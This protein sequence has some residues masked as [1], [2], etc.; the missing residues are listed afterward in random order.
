MF[1]EE[2]KDN[3]VV[4]NINPSSR[5]S[6][7]NPLKSPSATVIFRDFKIA[8]NARRGLNMKKLKGKTIRVVWHDRDNSSRY[9]SMNNLFIKN[10]PAEV[11]PREFY[12]FFL[13][14]GDIA[15]AKLPEDDDG[16]HLGYGYINYA[17]PQSAALAIKEADGSETWGSKIEVKNFQKKNE[18]FD[19][20][21][22]KNTNIYLKNFPTE[23]KE[24]DLESL[25]KKFGEVVH[26]K[27]YHDSNERNYAIVSYKDEDAALN[28]KSNLNGS[29][30]ENQ[31]I[32]VDTLMNKQD[33]KKLL[34]TQIKDYNYRINEQTKYC[35]LHIRNVPYNAKEEDLL[36]VFKP[37]GDIKS[38]KIDKYML[39]T[40]KNNEFIE[41]PTS[42]GFGYVCFENPESAAAAKEGMDGKFLPKFETWKRPLLVDF[43]MPKHER[44]QQMSKFQ[45]MGGLKGNMYNPQMMP[46]MNPMMM[47][48]MMNPQMMGYGQKGM[49][50]PQQQQGQMMNP[51][52]M[53]QQ[54]IQNVNQGYQKQ[55][56]PK[57]DTQKIPQQTPQQIPEQ[58]TQQ[59]DDID[60]KYLKSLDDDYAKKDYLGEH[61]FKKIENHKMSQEN[62]FTI[63]T[64]G[65]ITG[66]ILGIDDIN[67]II[68]ICRD[69]LNLTARIKE[70]LELL[71]V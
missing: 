35:N 36:E 28:A 15:S 44:N 5:Q 43:F 10:I 31:E 55:Q 25:C 64:I 18:R 59:K 65:K 51:Q 11:K 17:S 9:N 52:F 32:Y 4:I 48:Q 3:I 66:M 57:F 37:F 30:V 40:K 62:N 41:I 71:N 23:F 58:V 21:S 67:E 69:P 29:T 16:S 38:V 60:Y 42:K 46:G 53:P 56:K 27:I 1:F 7:Y 26:C 33:R 2:Y 24:K 34:N 6:E 8:D 68:Q 13:Q 54:G 47:N 50:F 19:S 12:E 61:I 49:R 39:V 70:A 63:D 22:L 45:Q 20:L 14:F